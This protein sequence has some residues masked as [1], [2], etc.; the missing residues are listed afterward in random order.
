MFRRLIIGSSLIVSAILAGVFVTADERHPQLAVEWVRTAAE[1]EALSL[2]AY[3][4]AGNFLPTAI[5][6]EG[7]SALPGQADAAGKPAA[8]IFDV[9]ETAVS[10]VEF[11]V[12]LEPP[13][14][15]SKLDNWSA[16][17]RATAVP[18]A[19]E[20][21]ELAID[22]GAELFFVTNRPCEEKPG[23]PDPCPQE[24]VTIDDLNEA[25]IP[26]DAEHVLLSN[27]RPAWSR[28]KSVRRQHIAATHRVIMLIGDD[29]GDF[30]PCTR[31]R[32]LAPCTEGATQ[33][34][35]REATQ[36]YRDYWGAG[37]FVLPNP[38]HGSWTTV[39]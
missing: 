3:R 17:N 27:E 18:G 25:G 16:T 9:D 36:R 15:N 19:A 2:Q 24:T 8:I 12:Q 28:E 32:P 1:F 35:R 6:D 14:R 29:L 20:F 39:E 21:V 4:A 13:F 11:Q 30:I 38:M 26:A 33:A 5:G 37:W 34:S 31:K 23:N 10:N 22:A 7:W